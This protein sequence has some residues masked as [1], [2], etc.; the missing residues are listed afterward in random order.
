VKSLDYLKSNFA[1]LFAKKSTL[2]NETYQKSCPCR[3]R[4]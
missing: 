3:L 2:V 4:V 1:L